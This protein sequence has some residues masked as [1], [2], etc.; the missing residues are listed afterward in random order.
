M[1][2]RV[3]FPSDEFDV[4]FGAGEIFT[5][6]GKDLATALAAVAAAVE[7]VAS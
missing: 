4:A 7:L 5:V 3:P 1:I 2:A 6:V